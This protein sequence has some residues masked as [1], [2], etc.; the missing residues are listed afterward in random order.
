MKRLIFGTAGAV[1]LFTAGC[2]SAPE[3]AKTAPLR[4]KTLVIEP[5]AGNRT[6]I[7]VGVIEEQNAALLSFP[8]GGTVTNVCVE[9]GSRVTRGQRLAEVDPTSAR[10]SFEAAQ[11]TLGQARDAYERLRQLHEAESLPEIQWVEA[12]T[13]LRQAEAAFGIARKNLDDCT[14]RAPFQG[15]VGS[16]RMAVGETV[17]PG[18]PVVTL[19]EIAR[20]KVRFSVPE[21]EIAALDDASLIEVRIPALG[22]TLLQAHALEKSPVA[23]PAAHTYD[24]RALLPNEGQRLLPGMVCRVRATAAHAPRQIVVPARVVQQA[25]DGSRFVWRVQGDSV[26]RAAITVGSFDANGVVVD[27]GLQAGDRIVVD[28]MQK[29]GQGSKIVM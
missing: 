14:L 27:T 21:Q 4:V 22:D 12:Q 29:I 5:S 16:R 24:V 17:L 13:R 23:N 9:E 10:Q 11:A 7:Y 15:V 26:V 25:G 20:V 2:S 28:G 18:V 1:M 6:G 3:S 8:V 19:L